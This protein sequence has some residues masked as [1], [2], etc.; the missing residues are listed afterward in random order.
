MTAIA[1]T[2]MM[3]AYSTSPCAS[4]LLRNWTIH[5]P[6]MARRPPQWS[7]IV[8]SPASPRALSSPPCHKPPSGG[9]QGRGEAFLGRGAPFRRRVAKRRGRFRRRV[10]KRDKRGVR[11]VLRRQRGSRYRQSCDATDLAFQIDDEPL[12]GP[13]PHTRRARQHRG[14]TRGDRPRDLRG[15]RDGQDREPSFRPDARDADE[16]LEER[17]FLPRLEAIERLVVLAHHLMRVQ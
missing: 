8:R 6:S 14:V 16:H 4:S 12:R 10:A 17:E 7:Q 9:T 5:A 3:S 15:T 2:A 1:M 13:L 11:V